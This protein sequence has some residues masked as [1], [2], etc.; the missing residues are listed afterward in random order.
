MSRDNVGELISRMESGAVT[1]A[2]PDNPAPADIVSLGAT[3]G[4]SFS[5]DDLGSFLRTRIA[6]AESLPRPWG[7]AVARQ[8]GLVRG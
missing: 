8:L 2:L 1:D 4:L 3:E 5:E 7:W 6:S